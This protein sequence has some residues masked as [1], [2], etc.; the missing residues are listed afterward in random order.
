MGWHP[1]QLCFRDYFINHII[2][3]IQCKVP[4]SSPDRWR[5]RFHPLSSGHVNS[6]SQKRS[7]LESPGTWKLID[8]ESV[9]LILWQ[10]VLAGFRGLQVDGNYIQQQQGLLLEES[11]L[12]TKGEAE[13][14]TSIWVIKRARMEEAGSWLFFWIFQSWSDVF[15]SSFS[16]VPIKSFVM[17]PTPFSSVPSFGYYLCRL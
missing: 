15:W 10:L 13:N 14:V 17:S 2:Q 7:R 12:P 3:V 1:T 11:R 8:R 9:A 16:S 6:P 5:S 4:F